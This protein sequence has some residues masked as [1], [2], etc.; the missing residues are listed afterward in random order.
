MSL[1]RVFRRLDLVKPTR[2]ATVD[3]LNRTIEFDNFAMP[4]RG[5]ADSVYALPRI[6][7]DHLKEN[8]F[9]ADGVFSPTWPSGSMYRS[10][11]VVPEDEAD[12]KD[13]LT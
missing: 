11:F 7:F 12:R 9:L 6:E 3:E 4:D 2:C 13:P 5:M 1:D 8:G 10:C